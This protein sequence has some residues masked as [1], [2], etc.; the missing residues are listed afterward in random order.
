MDQKQVAEVALHLPSNIVKLYVRGLHLEERYMDAGK[1]VSILEVFS[2]QT[3]NS[4][5]Q[6]R[7]KPKYQWLNEERE[8]IQNT[9]TQKEL[10]DK[11]YREGNYSQAAEWYASVMKIDNGARHK[12][13]S[14]S[15]V[16]EMETAGGRL[17]AVL[18]CNRAACLMALKEFDKAAKECSS[19][20]KIQKGYMK[21]IL[22]RA[23]CY[24]RIERFEE[25]LAEYS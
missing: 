23:R 25:S 15:N 3:K 24:A 20:L 16:W 17:H 14:S 2:Q 22:R 7:H 13:S 19:A 5:S 6:K 4:P 11:Y 1:A 12:S 21:A 18:H 10:G 9:V 8:K